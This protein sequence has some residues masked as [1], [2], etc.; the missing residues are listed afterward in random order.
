MSTGNAGCTTPLSASL[1]WA[2]VQR[3]ALS[4]GRPAA[5]INLKKSDHITLITEPAR[6]NPA[7]PAWFRYQLLGDPAGKAYFVGADCKLCN[8]PDWTY[9]QKNLK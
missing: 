4:G 1:Y 9:L 5:F 3:E 2:R 8:S 6:T 7:V